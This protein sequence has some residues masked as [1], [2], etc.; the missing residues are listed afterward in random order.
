MTYD[1]EMREAMYRFWD[2]AS[3][4]LRRTPFGEAAARR[5]SHLVALEGLVQSWRESFA[6]SEEKE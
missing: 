1:A 4:G 5:V 3:R 6:E 2:L